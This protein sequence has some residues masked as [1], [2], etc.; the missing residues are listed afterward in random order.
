MSEPWPVCASPGCDKPA[1]VIRKT[2]RREG[3]ERGKPAKHC[4][5]ECM[6]ERLRTPRRDPKE[7]TRTCTRCQVEKTGDLFKKSKPSQV[8]PWG[9]QR[10]CLECVNEQRRAVRPKR[11][12]LGRKLP[13]YERLKEEIL[14]GMS[15]KEL[16][17]KYGC[18]LRAV[19]AYAKNHAVKRGEWPLLSP[20]EQ[21]RRQLA[22]T[23][24]KPSVDGYFIRELLQEYLAESGE[25]RREFCERSRIKDNYLRHMLS[26]RWDARMQIPF[27]VRIM[28]AIGEP[29]PDWMLAVCETTRLGQSLREEPLR[30]GPRKMKR[31]DAA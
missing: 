2:D 10:V 5:R 6:E 7:V 8:N 24:K 30:G 23:K 13:R 31:L 21:K 16:A 9:I 28:Q 1:G 11:P 12:R 4:S 22:G 26:A 20:A 15:Y 19:T 3:R 29:V 14:S 18:T 25:T 27:A 17:V